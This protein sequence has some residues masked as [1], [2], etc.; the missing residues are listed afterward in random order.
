MKQT[1]AQNLASIS[2]EDQ[3]Y[4][5]TTLVTMEIL[6]GTNQ[7]GLAKRTTVL[8][9]SFGFDVITYRNADHDQYINSV[10]ID[11]KGVIQRAERAAAVI[12]CERVYTK[13]E[14]D[15]E[16]DVTLILGKDFDGRYCK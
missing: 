11:R 3:S 7:D 10:V 15:A 6:N 8:F 13:I 5:D 1:I 14:E 16:V 2:S 9:E 12:Q 4:D